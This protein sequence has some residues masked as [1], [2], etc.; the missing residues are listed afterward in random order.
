MLSPAAIGLVAFAS[1]FTYLFMLVATEAKN[2][3]AQLCIG[4]RRRSGE[5]RL[6]CWVGNIRREGKL[7]GDRG[8]E[9]GGDTVGREAARARHEVL[10]GCFTHCYTTRTCWYWK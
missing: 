3:T 2:T 6:R 8:G 7:G 9:M 1:S 10:H 5:V 4:C